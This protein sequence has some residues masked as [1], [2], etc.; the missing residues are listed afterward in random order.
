M[1]DLSKHRP[2]RLIAEL[3]IVGSVFLAGCSSAPGTQEDCWTDWGS[4]ATGGA[5]CLKPDNGAGAGLGEDSNGEASDDG[6]SGCAACV[7]SPLGI[8]RFG[9]S[10]SDILM[11]IA[12][13][14]QGNL[15][16]VGFFNGTLDFGAG[17]MTSHEFMDVFVVKLRHDGAVIWSKSF[18][19]NDEQQAHRVAIDAEG[20]ILIIGRFRGKVDFGGGPL[21]SAGSRDVFVVKLDAAGNHVWSKR[22]G[23]PNDQSGRGIAT[24][25]DGNVFIAGTVWSTIDFGSGPLASAGLEDI[26]VAKLDKA[27]QHIWS[28][29]FGDSQTQEAW[30]LATDGDGNVA[31][32]AY[33]LGDVD[34]GDGLTQGGAN[35]DAAVV[36]LG[37]DGATLWSHRY[38]DQQQQFGQSIAV[39]AQ[40]NVVLTGLM[41]GSVN[42]GDGPVQSAGAFDFFVAKF[43][44]TGKVR[45][46]RRYGDQY[47]QPSLLVA[48]DG[49]D[50]VLLT[51]FFLG[52]VDFG[53]GPLIGAGIDTFVAKLDRAGN[54]LWSH[55]MGDDAGQK[56]HGIIGGLTGNV[57]VIGVMEGTIE[58]GDDTVTNIGDFTEDAFVAHFSP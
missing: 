51:G 43:D 41:Q 54:Y 45:W 47:D 16:I 37:G 19:D 24:D 49:A 32:A 28:K 35:P 22:F 20:N 21:V 56:G 36:K 26:F 39:D 30:D 57:S 40:G 58:V 23:G 11:D 8:R 17:P 42:F 50:A 46:Y 12:T 38:G 55:R 31:M 2:W 29:L 27:G 53:G 3:V 52:S 1:T 25:K 6:G 9:D 48:V 34:L 14:R 15:I 5:S 18:G 13:D 7:G 10:G 44:L 4:A 33:V